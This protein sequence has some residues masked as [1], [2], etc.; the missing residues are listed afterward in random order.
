MEKSESVKNLLVSYLG[1]QASLQGINQTGNNPAFGKDNKYSTLSDIQKELLPKASK[2]GIAIIAEPL[3]NED[4]VGIQVTLYDVK[5]GEFM[6]YDPFTFT[7]AQINS[8]AN[9]VQNEGGIL[10]YAQ[11]YAYKAIFNISDASDDEDANFPEQNQ[12]NAYKSNN[13]YYN[14]NKPNTNNYTKTKKA[15]PKQ[16]E[17]DSNN[18]ING[19]DKLIQQN[20]KTLLE[21]FTQIAE[22]TKMS[23]KDIQDKVIQVSAEQDSNFLELTDSDTDKLKRVTTK[24]NWAKQ[25]L[26][27]LKK[28]QN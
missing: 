4:S 7:T 2:A 15:A 18:R 12:G 19:I 16:A 13:G 23:S 22:I 25:W 27:S 17:N 14:N 5:S 8:R 6:K 28:G 21:Y 20:E 1:L 3:T 11:R 26:T 24:I 9:A 10:T